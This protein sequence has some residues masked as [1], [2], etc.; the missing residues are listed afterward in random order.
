M[1]KNQITRHV[2]NSVTADGGL[3]AVCGQQTS[4]NFQSCNTVHVVFG[5]TDARGIVHLFFISMPVH[6]Q[7]TECSV[8]TTLVKGINKLAPISGRKL[9]TKQR[10]NTKRKLVEQG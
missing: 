3:Q 4:C 8:M 1:V 5:S 9:E 2:Y 7:R 10:K 6:V